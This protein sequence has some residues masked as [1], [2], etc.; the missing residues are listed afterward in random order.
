[1]K[2]PVYWLDS[3]ME[4]EAVLRQRLLDFRVTEAEPIMPLPTG[5]LQ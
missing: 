1:M 4:A 3:L 2:T 5:T